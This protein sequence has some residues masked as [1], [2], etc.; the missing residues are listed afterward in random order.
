MNFTCMGDGV[1]LAARLEGA[2][3]E[4]GT[5]I[6]I[7]EGT[8]V[9][10]GDL[11]I[12]RPLDMLKVKGKTKPAKVFELI[13]TS[14]KGVSADMYRVLELFEKGFDN[15]LQQN[16]DWAINYF[17]QVLSIKEDDAPSQ[18]YIARCKRFKEIPPE[19]GW[20]GVFTMT[21]K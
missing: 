8:V 4:Y 5:L 19:A 13:G 17:Q 20:E 15:Y 21:T 3:K 2:N 9:E 18:R 7:G 16:W 12:V 11:I 10:A 1:N 14:E 6:M